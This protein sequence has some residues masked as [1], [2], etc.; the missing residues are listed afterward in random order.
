M[1]VQSLPTEPR[2]YVEVFGDALE[3]PTEGSLYVVRRPASD[4]SVPILR[5]VNSDQLQHNGPAK[6]RKTVLENLLRSA[7]L[8]PDMGPV[9]AQNEFGRLI[10]ALPESTVLADGH[11]FSPSEEPPEIV[12]FLLRRISGDHIVPLDAYVPGAF[13]M[14]DSL[15]CVSDVVRTKRFVES[16]G[17]TVRWLEERIPNREIRVCDAGCGSLPVLS[18][19]AA[20]ASSR[21][22]CT[23]LELNPRSAAMAR[24]I[25]QGMGLREQ[26]EVVETDILGYEPS[27]PF[28]VVV[29]ETMDVGLANEPLVQVMAHMKQY[30]SPG[31]VMLPQSVILKAA[32]VSTR[33]QAE[34]NKARVVVNNAEYDAIDP[35]WVTI[36]SYRLGQT[37][38]DIH[39][40]IG[41]EGGWE[42]FFN[43]FVTNTVQIIG[44][45][46]LGPYNSAITLAK[47][48]KQDSS[49]VFVGAAIGGKSVD[50][51]VAYPPGGTMFAR[52]I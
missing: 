28:D 29:S 49:R 24:E 15:R 39:Y 26:I 3:L 43:L 34:R 31:G 40:H 50:V 46:L 2:P 17:E 27:E 41:T 42:G 19:A 5:P 45:Q 21:V 22:K 7:Q 38:E 12:S 33:R 13:T 36:G 51:C 16:V 25:I 11:H 14:F 9:D 20:L 23:A 48:V 37:V 44:G 35:D 8:L 1:T 18:I 4:C 6:I 10:H 47:Q 52:H 30:I 32:F